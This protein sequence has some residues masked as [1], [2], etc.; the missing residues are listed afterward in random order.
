MKEAALKATEMVL[1]FAS[2]CFTLPYVPSHEIARLP[3]LPG[4]IFAVLLFAGSRM[5]RWRP[6]YLLPTLETA[7]FAAF[8]W[9]SNSVANLIY[10]TG[11]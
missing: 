10:A 9:V 3:L 4:A 7:I 1:L 6:H 11:A 5:I 2:L 8:V